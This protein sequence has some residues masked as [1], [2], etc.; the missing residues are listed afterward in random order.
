MISYLEYSI[1]ILNNLMEHCSHEKEVKKMC[2]ND[3]ENEFHQIF[4]IFFFF[5]Y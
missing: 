2:C 3:F 4:P 1:I 5:Y